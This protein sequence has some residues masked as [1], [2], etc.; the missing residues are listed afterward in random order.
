MAWTLDTTH[1]LLEFS[2]KH[3][4][5]TT[6][7]G[8]FRTFTAELALDEQNPTASRVEATIDVASLDTNDPNRD[9]HLRSPDFFDIA[10]YPTAT[11]KST[12]IEPKGANEYRIYGDLT[13]NGITKPVT[14]DAAVEGLFTDMQGK[15]RA[16]ISAQTSFNRKDYGLNWNVALETGGVLVSDK[17]NIAVEAQIIESVPAELAEASAR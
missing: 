14:L 1:S 12:R 16:A 6:V 2:V 11:F 7:K 13:I 15:R 8:R 10:Q 3:M 9:G 17:V 5:F 4:M